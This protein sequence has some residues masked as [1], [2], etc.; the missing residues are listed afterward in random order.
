MAEIRSLIVAQQ[1][2]TK[3]KT[4]RI[5]TEHNNATDSGIESTEPE[6]V[7]QSRAPGEKK[8]KLLILCWCQGDLNP[9]LFGDC[10]W[11]WPLG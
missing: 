9:G 4:V 3:A 1:D 5:Q 11:R 2:R 7:P 10:Q 8:K 6:S